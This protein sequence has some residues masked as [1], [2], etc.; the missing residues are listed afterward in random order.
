M[1]LTIEKLQNAGIEHVSVSTNYRAAKII[2]HFGDGKAFGI[3]LNY[4]QEDRP[5]GTA[6]A[7][8]LMEPPKN[9]LLVINGD[10][11]TQMDL[12][13][14]FSYHQEQK[15]EIT[16]GVRQFD[17]QIPYGVL[18]CEG[19]KVRELKEKPQVTFLVNAG[20]YLLEP[21]VFD[22]I[23]KGARLDMTELIQHL[24][25][26]ERHVVSF[27]IIEYWLDIGQPA[28]YDQAQSDAQAGKHNSTY[29]KKG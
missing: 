12:R 15:A 5:L 19:P 23:T 13:K 21:S 2:E 16:V 3:E 11:I 29:D 22:F 14:M 7:L 17:V 20:I 26:N 10:V 27:P 25:D 4:I 24:L 28:D 6:G 1:E 8:G 9:T 18:E